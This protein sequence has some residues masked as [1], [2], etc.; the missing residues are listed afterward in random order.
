MRLT[1]S[2]LRR[3][4]LALTAAA[5]LALAGCASNP[6]S[7]P[8]SAPAPSSTADT[9]SGTCQYPADGQA[10]KQADAPDAEPTAAGEV[11]ATIKTSAGDLAVTLDADKT[12]CTTNSFLS[13]AKQTYFDGTQCHRL[14]TQGIFVLQCGDPSGT[15][16]GG[17][18]YSFADELS[19]D[20]TYGA[21]TLAMANAGPDTN[22]SQFFIVYADSEL[23]PN[24]TVFGHLDDASTKIVAGIGAEGTKD[25]GPDGAPKTPVTL[26]QVTQD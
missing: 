23:P 2:L 1:P 22:G 21:G 13:L 8:A 19:G 24:Y 3:S 15:G 6:A 11:S 17:P 16:A 20:E 14:T 4:L 25:G 12:P 5:A 9:A 26:L 7:D 18:G 10:A